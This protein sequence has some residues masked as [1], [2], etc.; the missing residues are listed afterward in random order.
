MEETTPEGNGAAGNGT[1]ASGRNGG[2]KPRRSTSR[3][4]AR[5]N[6][7]KHGVLSEGAVLPT[8]DRS[9]FEELHNNLREDL[10]PRGALDELLVEKI[11]TCFW[12]LRRVLGHDFRFEPDESEDKR[13][14][15]IH[16]DVED[17]PSPVK[18]I[19][20]V[21][22]IPVESNDTYTKANADA[23][24][25]Q[26]QSSLATDDMRTK[27]KTPTSV[28]DYKRMDTFL[29]YETTIERQLYRAIDQLE[30]LQRQRA[31]DYVP[32][33]VKVGVSTDV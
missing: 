20:G 11:A 4:V 24:T 22:G 26:L 2:G 14:V 23:G 27:A 8:E 10:K 25:A 30:R 28:D 32:P 29:R 18:S 31:G 21:D 17:Y 13:P 19:R 7:L 5:W 16:I 1:G 9:Q 12:R 6:A 15:I 3:S 33:P